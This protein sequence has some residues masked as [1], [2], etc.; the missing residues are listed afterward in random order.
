MTRFLDPEDPFNPGHDLMRRRVG[1]LIEIDDAVPDVVDER[2]LKRRV[3]GGE[4]GVV[5]GSYVEAVVVLEEDRPL[6]SVNGG[7][8]TLGLDHEIGVVLSWVVVG[9]VVEL[10]LGVQYA[11]VF[12]SVL[13]L[14]LIRPGNLDL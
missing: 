3:T 11:V 4:R 8:E 14:L 7:C 5:S 2:P 13:L 6:G 12:G 9:A 10:L 1:G